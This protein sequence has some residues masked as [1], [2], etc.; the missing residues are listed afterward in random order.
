ME[1]LALMVATIL[2]ATILS[3]PAVV[4]V[5]YSKIPTWLLF[6]LC[7]APLILGLHLF[8][9]LPSLPARLVGLLPIACVGWA[10]G[11]RFNTRL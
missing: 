7:A 8:I 4:L 11:H 10:I 2:A 9:N 6:I 5:S 1:S 3:G